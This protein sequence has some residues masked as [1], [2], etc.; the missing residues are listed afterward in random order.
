MVTTGS[1]A[2][3]Y[4][5]RRNGADQLVPCLRPGGAIPPPHNFHGV[6]R[7]KFALFSSSTPAARAHSVQQL[8]RAWH[9]GVRIPKHAPN[10]S[11]ARYPDQLRVCLYLRQMRDNDYDVTTEDKEC[12]GGNENIVS[13]VKCSDAVNFEDYTASATDGMRM[14]HWWN[15]TDR[16]KL[17]YWEKN[18]IQR[19]W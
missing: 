3:V 13:S 10:A 1:T 17:K 5:Q 2:V 8:P 9:S 12:D 4:I 19:G 6:H 18:I 11:I 14:E 15:D 16:G 7:D